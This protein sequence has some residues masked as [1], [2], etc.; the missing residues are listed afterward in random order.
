MAG[1]IKTFQKNVNKYRVS[2]D[3]N[4]FGSAEVITA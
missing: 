1:F 2:A 3:P 4:I